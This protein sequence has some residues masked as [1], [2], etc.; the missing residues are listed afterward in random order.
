MHPFIPITKPQSLPHDWSLQLR[1][2]ISIPSEADLWHPTNRMTDEEWARNKAKLNLNTRALPFAVMHAFNRTPSS[3]SSLHGAHAPPLLEH[4]KPSAVFNHI[5]TATFPSPEG[6]DAPFTVAIRVLGKLGRLPGRTETT[7]ALMT[8]ARYALGLSEVPKVYG[9]CD[10]DATTGNPVNAPYII[11]EYFPYSPTLD[12][13]KMWYHEAPSEEFWYELTD[14]MAKAHTELVKSVPFSTGYGSVY[15]DSDRI[16]SDSTTAESSRREDDARLSDIKTYKLGPYM[17]GPMEFRVGWSER[18]VKP[19]P[20]IGSESIRTPS[21][22]SLR[23]FWELLWTNEVGAVKEYYRAK[24]GALSQSGATIDGG[25]GEGGSDADSD[26]SN[27]DD[28]LRTVD[29]LLQYIK[30]VPLPDYPRLYTPSIV[31]NFYATRNVAIHS[32]TEPD[33]GSH[34]I[35]IKAYLDWDNTFI[36]PFILASQYFHELTD[37]A[38]E[39]TPHWNEIEGGFHCV[40]AITDDGEPANDEEMKQVF[41]HRRIVYLNRTKAQRN[42]DAEEQE[43]GEWDSSDEAKERRERAIIRRNRLFNAHF[44]REY[45]RALQRH[46][47]RFSIPGLWEARNDVLKIHFLVTGG[48]ETWMDKADWIE[49]RARE[50]VTGNL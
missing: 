37:G 41:D 43:E 22:T 14:A 16:E 28:I 17:P 4:T 12:C 46:D 35:Q 32:R 31:P 21:S 44:Q 39:G 49:R 15:F 25:E 11:T 26:D 30:H 47:T 38:D 27:L 34:Q 24:P 33:S 3:S 10:G 29:H 36:L 45:E 23:S 5:Y 50:V 7:V 6:E 18:K 1:N 48:M 13:I 19:R 42:P 2:T 8:F 40:Q 9:W 20:M